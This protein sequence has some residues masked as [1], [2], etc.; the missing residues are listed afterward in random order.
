MIY[1]VWICW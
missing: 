1:C